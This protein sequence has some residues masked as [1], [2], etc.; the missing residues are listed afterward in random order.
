MTVIEV[1][2]LAFG[3]GANHLFSGITFS[4]EQG[5][6]ACLVAPNGAG[7][8]TLLRLIAHELV[9]DG[10]SVVVRKD[11]RVAYARQSHELAANGTVLDAFLG[12]F[13]DVVNLRRALSVAE[14]EAASGTEAA[15][16]ALARA[17]DRYHLA[18]G[19]ELERRVSIIASHLG[20]PPNPWAARSRAF[21]GASVDGCTSAPRWPKSLTFSCWTS[22]RTTST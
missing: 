14:H 17:M 7:K 21:R 20:F 2:N 18:G 10:G 19:D 11:A 13:S 22:P 8:S 12:A 4:L 9:P 1:A 16:A 6:R 5:E 15:L 3:Y